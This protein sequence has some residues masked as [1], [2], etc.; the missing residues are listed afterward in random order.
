MTRAECVGTDKK[1][2]DAGESPPTDSSR[3]SNRISFIHSSIRIQSIDRVAR[4]SHQSP[5][6]RRLRFINNRFFCL[7]PNLFFGFGSP[8]RRL[9]RSNKITFTARNPTTTI[10]T[11]S[12]IVTAV[13]ESPIFARSRPPGRSKRARART[14]RD[15]MPRSREFHSMRIDSFIRTVVTTR[16]RARLVNSPRWRDV[17]FASSRRSI[18][19]LRARERE[20]LPAPITVIIIESNRIESIATPTPTLVMAEKQHQGA[21]FAQPHNLL[22]P[23]VRLAEGRFTVAAAPKLGRGQFAEVYAASDA[24]RGGAL[25]AIKIESEHRT[26]AR[27][28]RVMRAM[29]GKAHFVELLSE[30]SHEGKPFLAMELVGENLADLRGRRSGGR[31]GARTTSAIAVAMLEALESV[32]EAG[33]VHRDIKPGNVCIGNG[34]DGMKRLYLI[35]FGLARKYTDDAGKPLPEREDAT[36]R[37][38]TTYASVYAHEH[39]EQSA[40]DDLFSALYVLAEAHE[41]VLPWKSGEE[42]KSKQD[43][44]RLKKVCVKDPKVLCP[45]QGCPAPIE[46]FARAISTLKYGETPNYAELRAPFEAVIRDSG[47]AP[48][49]WE[50]APQTPSG[51]RAPPPPSGPAPTATYADV[52]A[53]GDANITGR[54]RERDED[55]PPD[56]PPAS[57]RFP[58]GAL[59]RMARQEPSSLPADIADTV[60]RVAY[61]FPAEDAL[62]VASGLVSF[63]LENTL[64][65]VDP[66]KFP[67][68]DVMKCLLDLRDI[69]FDGVG[70][71]RRQPRDGPRDGSRDGA[72]D[73]RGGDRFGGG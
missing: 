58:P 56:A 16:A 32:H 55:A 27:E 37:G 41:G 40:R 50:A 67:R 64:D 20:R 51:K 35:D 30:S 31:F 59:V 22:K 17:R 70:D 23:G 53:N 44:E 49:D 48:L 24:E 7:A 72:R 47:D 63:V 14:T 6:A 9:A 21:S 15:E 61:R 28:G 71:L 10:V 66:V 38:T 33:Y 45:T 73:G 42:K 11:V 36:F 68:Q 8:N 69:C 2:E 13:F 57:R 54:K 1:D 43:V 19:A 62:A 46:N 25:V 34:K 12:T 4:P 52:A 18:R 26:S 60:R 3:E 5:P 29:A 39:K 65:A